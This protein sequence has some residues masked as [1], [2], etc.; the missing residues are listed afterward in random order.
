VLL[1]ARNHKDLEDVPESVRKEMTFV[2]LERV[3]DASDRAF[4]P[5]GQES[6]K[7]AATGT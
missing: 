7:F 3:A 4:E 1:P 5:K 6:S 2:W